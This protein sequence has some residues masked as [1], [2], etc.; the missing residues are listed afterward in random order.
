MVPAGGIDLVLT[1][2][3]H[4]FKWGG[5]HLIFGL[6]KNFYV[7]HLGGGGG[8]GVVGSLLTFTALS[9]AQSSAQTHIH[10]VILVIDT[11]NNA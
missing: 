3:F 11:S 10:S 1:Y 4:V 8:G 6:R 7:F 9:D 5:G 2:G